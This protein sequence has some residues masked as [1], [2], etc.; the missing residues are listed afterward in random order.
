VDMPNDQAPT[1]LVGVIKKFLRKFVGVD[2]DTLRPNT[3]RDPDPAPSEVIKPRKVVLDTP[4]APAAVGKVGA[5]K[6]FLLK[7]AGIDLAT[8][9]LCPQHDWD[10][11]VAVAEIMILVVI[12]QTV[13]FVLVGHQLWASPGQIRPEIILG[14]V[15][16]A[17]FIMFIDSY[18]IMRSGW[19][20]SGIAE[21]KRGGLDIGGG[22]AARTKA[23]FFLVFRIMLSIGLAQLTAIFVSLLI[24]AAD[25]NVPIE[26][27]YLEANRHLVGPATAVVDAEIQHATASVK[28]RTEQVGTLSDQVASLRQQEIDPAGSN[29]QVQ[30]AQREVEQLLAQKAQADEDIRNAET[31]AANEMGGRNGAQPGRGLRWRAAMEQ[32]ASGKARSQELGR[33]LNAARERLD[34]LRRKVPPPDEA[35]RRRTHDQRRAFEQS[36]DVENAELSRL[37]DE[38]AKLTR[39]RE[40]AIRRAIEDAP[41]HV[42]ADNG[43]LAR[44]S[45]LGRIA[46]QDTKI[47][48]VIILID[49]ISFGFELAAVLAKVTSYVPTTYAALLARDAYI[50]SVR[51]VD[52][53]L[54]QLKRPEILPPEASLLPPE[55]PRDDN[56]RGA[57]AV[58]T[59]KLPGDS[60]GEDPPAPKRKRGRPRKSFPNA[61]VTSASERE[62]QEQPSDLPGPA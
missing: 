45:Q 3:P 16:I 52:D 32:S 7:I 19:H 26:N 47:A 20:L 56:Q 25:V 38:L 12:Y 42:A 62:G 48:L 34:G 50:R 23:A 60:D 13:L 59:P 43:F 30:Q 9:R 22:V 40:Q 14:S 21:L 15:F 18:M 33:A 2:E 39:G 46:E 4:N 55:P 54:S 1:G 24:F 5:V 41:D 29:P 11:A 36:L 10:N 61:S 35:S 49:V 17:V 53:M 31:S 44:I 28:N 57:A 6:R 8:L 51:I 58:A 27:K 37:K